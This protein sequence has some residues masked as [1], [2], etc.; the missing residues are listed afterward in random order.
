MKKII[1]GI[2]SLLIVGA[3]VYAC[4]SNFEAKPNS[5]NETANLTINNTKT[6]EVEK[7]EVKEKEGY[8]IIVSKKDIT[9]EKG[10]KTSFEITFTNPDEISIREYIHCEDQNNIILVEYT[11]L[12]DKKITVQVEAL[13]AGTTE[14]VVCDF[15]YP[16]KK[17]IVKVNVTEAK[18]IDVSVEYNDDNLIS[19]FAINNHNV[20]NSMT[21]KTKYKELKLNKKLVS[22][23]LV[24]ADIYAYGTQFNQNYLFIYDKNGK[25]IDYIYSL[26][27]K[28]NDNN[29]YKYMGDFEYDTDTKKLSFKTSL[30]L[31]DGEE[32]T[33]VAFNNKDISELSK[34]ELE[35]FKNYA[36][37][38][39]YEY[40]L[41]NGKFEFV[42]KEVISKIKD[43]EFLKSYFN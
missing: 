16:D 2:V 3:I 21:E 22:D 40:K 18:D 36:D 28:D 13:K 17:E 23:N 1:I 31:G 8:E 27:D 19:K 37:E 11:P 34:S 26:E 35:K 29:S 7:K 38:V 39:K 24:F 25:L 41:K 6:Q 42:K 14:I 33:G 10:E 20:F 43:N 9:I 12:E 5:K 30:W 4:I 15:E 32:D